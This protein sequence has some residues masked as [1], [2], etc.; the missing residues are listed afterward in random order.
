MASAKQAPDSGGVEPLAPT[1]SDGMVGCDSV[2]LLPLPERRNQPLLRDVPP[3]AHPP[4]EHA[5][6]DSETPFC[7]ST[8]PP[9]GTQ[10]P[11]AFER[12]S[13]E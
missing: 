1:A 3:I 12:I 6:L 5:T 2:Q 8:V 9:V 4:E 10:G 13:V 7:A 11:V